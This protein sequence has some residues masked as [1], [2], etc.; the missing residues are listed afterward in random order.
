MKFMFLDQSLTGTG[1]CVLDHNGKINV[2]K[3]LK[4]KRTPKNAKEEIQRLKC[5]LSEII[6]IFKK[7][8]PESIGLEEYGFGT[9]GRAFKLGELGGVIK[10]AIYERGT[11]PIILRPGQ[12][13]KF[14]TGKGNTEKNL[15]LMNIYKKYGVSCENDNEADALVGA[16]ILKAKYEIEKKI[17][18]KR[19]F[20]KQEWAV[21]KE[22]INK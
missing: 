3:T 1:L 13:K 2:L 6:H 20:T 19:D 8:R 9:R 22:I 11:C 5:I 14:L 21:L 7:E 16:K 18:K 15:M 4:Q 17:K 12:I 10:L